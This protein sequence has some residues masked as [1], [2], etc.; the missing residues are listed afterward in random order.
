MLKPGRFKSNVENQIV[1]I[2]LNE[3]NIKMSIQ[4]P[5]WL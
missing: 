5:A 1:Q 2:G 4:K 3:L